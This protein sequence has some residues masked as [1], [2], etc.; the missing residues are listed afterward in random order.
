MKDDRLSKL[1]L[2]IPAFLFLANDAPQPVHAKAETRLIAQGDDQGS[3]TI[4]PEKIRGVVEIYLRQ[5]WRPVGGAEGAVATIRFVIDKSGQVFGDPSVKTSGG[6]ADFDNAAVEAIKGVGPLPALPD[7]L[8][9]QIAFIAKF[10]AGKSAWV[11][12]NVDETGTPPL[13]GGSSGSQTATPETGSASASAT[14]ASLDGSPAELDASTASTTPGGTGQSGWTQPSASASTTGQSGWTQPSPSANATGQSGW[15]QTSPSANATGQ[16]GWTQPSGTPAPQQPQ[17]GEMDGGTQS[18][19]GGGMPSSPEDMNQQVILLNNKAVV[20]IADNNYELAIKHLE[21][22]LRIN[23]KYQQAR[24]NLAIA[25]NNYGL[26]LKD[27]PD[28]AIKVFHKALAL[29]PA[30]VKTKTNLETI[31]SYMGKNAANFKDRLDLGNKAIAQGDKLGARIEWEAALAIK[32]DPIVQQKLSALINGTSPNGTPDDPRRHHGIQ[33]GQGAHANGF[34][35]NSTGAVGQ[36]TQA[37]A[38]GKTPQKT[39]PGKGSAPGR[40]AT[41]PG[42]MLNAGRPAAG[43]IKIVPGFGAGNQTAKM[44]QI[45]LE[46]DTADGAP[47]GAV[48]QRLDTMYRNLKNLEVKT[49]GKPYDS[50][51]ILSRLARLE[52]KL[53]GKVQSGKPMR[54]LDALLI[55]Q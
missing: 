9:S 28:E 54:R 24:A 31:I 55:L 38:Q 36:H 14:A 50:D 33:Q 3:G 4:T 34:P 45:D 18:Q 42:P 11:E 17:Q 48:S 40:T 37:N 35:Q 20:A 52:K 7:Y 12:L 10:H 13:G 43:A 19:M 21:E 39:P 25:Y 6:G 53:L 26:Q 49:F 5:K 23:N 30:N 32:P 41:P 1:V 27:R 51:D 46:D 8:G 2:L 22:A 47:A 29:D 16:S 44:P 15:T